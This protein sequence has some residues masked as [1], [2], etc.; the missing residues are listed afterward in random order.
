MD[1]Q[2]LKFFFTNWIVTQLKIIIIIIIPLPYL[3][4]SLTSVR[5]VENCH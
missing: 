1:L 5:P 3:Y 4:L 2:V